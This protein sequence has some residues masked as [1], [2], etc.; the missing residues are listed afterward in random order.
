MKL[1]QLK[2]TSYFTFTDC[3][4]LSFLFI[5]FYS[6]ERGSFRSAPR[7]PEGRGDQ[8]DIISRSVLYESN[9][10]SSQAVKS[11]IT[12]HPCIF[13]LSS[14]AFSMDLCVSVCFSRA[15]L[16][17]KPWDY[18]GLLSKVNPWGSFN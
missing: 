8:S 16:T 5:Y 3:F 18:K 11:D 2:G 1:L 7:K 13:S 15:D 10:G 12:S 4:F 17:I 6:S 9:A 14:S